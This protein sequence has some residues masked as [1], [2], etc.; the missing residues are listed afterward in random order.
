ME[1]DKVATY[2]NEYFVNIEKIAGGQ[3]P[4]G[5]T[6]SGVADDIHVKEAWSLDQFCLEEVLTII[7]SIIVSKSSGI[8]NV[9]SSR[10]SSPRSLFS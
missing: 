6:V 7:K 4:G 9:S 3:I 2:I 5:R 8:T 1:K 10:Y